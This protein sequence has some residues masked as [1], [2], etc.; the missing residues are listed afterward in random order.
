MA[1]DR[2]A[3]I[4][5]LEAACAGLLFVSEQDAP[6]AIV[7]APSAALD[8][9]QLH[10]LAGRP[11]ADPI[12]TIAVEYFFR[13]AILDQEWHSPAEKA[14]VRR[15]RAL[16][17]LIESALPDARVFRLGARRVSVLIVGTGP[18]G[19]ILGLS[20]TVVET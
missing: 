19:G 14:A 4:R 17:S 18:D 8:G 2:S 1:T 5:Q 16:V 11:A 13:N 10:A 9:E 3:L 20:T 6:F 15:Y 12:E 7:D